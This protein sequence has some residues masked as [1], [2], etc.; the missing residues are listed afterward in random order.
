MELKVNFLLN[1]KLKYKMVLV[2]IVPIMGILFFGSN[3]VK[4]N[5]Q[6]LNEMSNVQ[7]LTEF[8]VISSKLVHELQKERGASAGFLGAKGKSFGKE[9]IQQRKETDSKLKDFNNYIKNN[10]L[11]EL[12]SA[13][14]SL[15][16]NA[17]NNLSQINKMRAEVDNLQVSVKDEVGYYT[18]INTNLLKSI[19]SLSTEANDVELSKQASAYISLLKG[20][21]RAGIERAVLSNTFANDKFGP[22]MYRK[23]ISLVAQQNT[24]FNE[25][26]EKATPEALSRLKKIESSKVSQ[27][28]EKMRKAA[29]EY[30]A[31][32]G[33]NTD[34]TFWFD[35]KTKQINELKELEDYLSEQILTL[36][37]NIKSNV[38]F[39]LT[40]VLVLFSLSIILSFFF[41]F[42][43]IKYILKAIKDLN[44]AAENISVGAIDQSVPL[45]TTDELGQLSYSFRELIRYLKELGFAAESIADFDLTAKIRKRSDNDVLSQAFEKMMQNLSKIISNIAKNSSELAAAA[46]EISTTS[47][48]ISNGSNDNSNQVVQVAAAV[49]EMTANILESN[50]NVSDVLKMAEDS[51]AT[52]SKGGEV[53]TDTVSCMEN[54]SKTV[55]ESASSIK[56]L[57]ESA[58]QIGSI[59]SVIDEIADQTNLLALNAAIEAA[60]AGEQG[61]GFAVVADEVRNLADRTTKATAEISST[62]KGI[63]TDT[64]KAVDAMESG[65]KEVEHGS[66]L[67]NTASISLNEIVE[68]SSGVMQMVNQLTISS[69][70]QAT[71]VEQI[72]E[73]IDK[74]AKVTKET[75][76][77][78]QQSAEASESL[79]IQAENLQLIVSKFKLCNG[80]ECIIE[81][82]KKDHKFYMQ[83]LDSGIKS[84]DMAAMWRPV[85]HMNCRFG[86]WYYSD[87]SK[88][89]KN[90]ISFQN[91]ASVHD[92]VHKKANEAIELALHGNLKEASAH[93][94][95]SYKNSQK[96]IGLLDALKE[97]MKDLV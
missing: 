32:G 61:R 68:M 92:A 77:G 81:S 78:S 54:I 31:S 24:Y 44:Y 9:L 40:F 3:I 38:Q 43:L 96:L 73:N 47:N 69:S 2:V 74:V 66:T 30:A 48:Q 18:D 83:N 17:K 79:S 76:I 93:R 52:A 15:I 60:R 10:D 71:T 50:S 22:G 36:S 85:D 87:K 45:K 19:G 80:E 86:K 26:S 59:I 34:A 29:I 21:E 56:K 94:D 16:N 62:I 84:K 4:T 13:F 8:S 6:N 88:H 41:S 90:D 64:N 14:N 42:F 82:A 1:L 53:V 67:T 12:S 46:T 35:Q 20:K 37:G 72:S 89:L 39:E 70:E 63:Q 33:F 27:E 11:Q 91:I 95:I 28:V 97:T 75:T 7:E 57:A 25:F 5:W 65:I 49:E 23:F 51:A 58:N 55:S